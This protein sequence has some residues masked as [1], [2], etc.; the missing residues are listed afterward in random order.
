MFD[1]QAPQQTLQRHVDLSLRNPRANALTHFLPNVATPCITVKHID[2]THQW[3]FEEANPC[4]LRLPAPTAP[5]LTRIH[6]SSP[7][8]LAASRHGDTP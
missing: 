6:P 3:N 2:R 7:R 4:L 1:Q 8:L 5:A